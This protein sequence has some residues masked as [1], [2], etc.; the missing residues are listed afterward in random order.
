MKRETQC[1]LPTSEGPGVNTP[2]YPS[3]SYQY[4]GHDENR[5]P[6]Y[7]NTENQQVIAGKIAAL[8]SAESGLVFASGMA[9]ISTALL[10]FVQPGDHVIFSDELY[11]GTHK[12]ITSELDRFGIQYDFVQSTSIAAYEEAIRPETRLLYTESPSNP[13][14]TIV[15]LR[16]LG[17]LANKHD[18]ISMIDNTFATPIN[19]RPIEYGFDVVLHSGTKYLGG[20]SD[21][22]FGAAVGKEKYIQ[23]INTRAINYGGSL[24][25]LDCY[26]IERSLKT[27][28]VRVKQQNHNALEIATFLEQHPAVKHVHYPGLTSHPGHHIAA[29]QMT[30]GFGG[31]LSFELQS[32]GHTDIFLKALRLVVPALS[33]GGVETIICQPSKTS[34]IKMSEAE[35]LKLGITD[36]T[37]RLS[38]G[39]EAIE[40]LKD[41]LVTALEVSALTVS[42]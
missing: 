23:E 36:G 21:L 17:N 41:D 38:V 15:D 16:A 35:R 31:M 13:L 6:R 4:M 9:A 24:N 5:Y 19:Q 25:A 40:D 26:L 30:A 18:I 32:A 37:L 27:L 2:I 10:S 33:L 20:H 22:C 14:V 3:S 11:G 39:I 1:V 28:A 12:F 8:E 7:F 34:H 29:G 42:L